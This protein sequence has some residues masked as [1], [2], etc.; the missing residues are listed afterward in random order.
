MT[1]Y[2]TPDREG[3]WWAKLKLAENPDDNSTGWEVVQVFDNIMRPWC[4]ADALAYDPFYGDETDIAEL[5]DKIVTAAKDHPHCQICH[6]QIAKG[7]RH[8]AKVERNDEEHKIMTFRFCGE[9]C[10]AMAVVH[11][12]YDYTSNPDGF[13]DDAINARQALGNRRRDDERAA[14]SKALSTGGE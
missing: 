14:I 11:A 7:E 9:C 6:G 4:E 3:H 8:R 10:A 5:S 2:P 12:D 1:A 13:P